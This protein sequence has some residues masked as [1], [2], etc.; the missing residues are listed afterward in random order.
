MCD[1]KWMLIMCD[2]KWML[3]MC[4]F[5]VAPSRTL[6]LVH[7]HRM[8]IM[9]DFKWMLIM[10][11]FKWMLIM[12]D[13]KVAPS[14]TLE[15][16]KKFRYDL[17]DLYKRLVAIQSRYDNFPNDNQSRVSRDGTERRLSSEKS[18]I[19]QEMHGSFRTKCMDSP[20]N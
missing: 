10:C 20:L 3:I 7:D 18:Y 19:S 4:D 13:F 12:C 2:F 9:C 11:D 14:R 5:K 15:Q 17:D 16:Y 1:F 8:L 6:G